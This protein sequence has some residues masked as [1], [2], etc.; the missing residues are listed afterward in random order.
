MT[1]TEM[2]YVARCPEPG[3]TSIVAASIDDPQHPE[4]ALRDVSNW[5]RWKRPHLIERI[6]VEMARKDLMTCDHP[7]TTG[8]A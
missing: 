2:A 7:E 3:C 8:D 1:E 4:R 5:S 6:L